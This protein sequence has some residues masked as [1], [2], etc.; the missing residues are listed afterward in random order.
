MVARRL[1][2]NRDGTGHDD[3]VQDGLVA[4]SVNDHHIAG[5]NGMV[6]DHLVRCARAIGHEEAMVSVENPCRIAFGRADGAVV[7]KQLAQFL[8]RVAHIGAQHVFAVELVVH[9]P[10]G[11]FQKGDTARMPGTVP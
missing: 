1:H 2:E 6:P 4:V 8:D 9:L 5:G 11:A 10:N 3:A 7:V